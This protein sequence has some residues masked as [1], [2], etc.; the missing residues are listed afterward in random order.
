MDYYRSNPELLALHRCWKSEKMDCIGLHWTLE[1]LTKQQTP[2]SAL[3]K[4]ETKKL[5]CHWFCSY[6]SMCS[7]APWCVMWRSSLL[8]QVDA[9]GNSLQIIV[10]LTKPAPICAAWQGCCIIVLKPNL[11][12]Q[13]INSSAGTWWLEWWWGISSWQK[14]NRVAVPAYYHLD[15]C[16]TQKHWKKRSR[17]KGVRLYVSWKL[18]KLRGAVKS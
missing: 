11:S 10:I 2:Q 6:Q 1:F 17:K 18:V 16:Y 14:H 3:K 5:S 7:C 13:L 12:H 9:M 15:G 8:N 4:K